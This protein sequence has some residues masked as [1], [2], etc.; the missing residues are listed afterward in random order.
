MYQKV[1]SLLQC[2]HLIYFVYALHIVVPIKEIQ[3]K[4]KIN[5]SIISGQRKGKASEVQGREARATAHTP[6]RKSEEGF[7]KGQG[8]TK[9][10]GMFLTIPWGGLSYVI[11]FLF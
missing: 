1:L 3:H 7:R 4:K 6:R 9:E 11:L 8:R 5:A 2:L 10:N